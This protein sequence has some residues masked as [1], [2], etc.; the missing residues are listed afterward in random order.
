MAQTEKFS[1][2]RPTVS[3]FDEPKANFFQLF[4]YLHIL[5]S[6]MRRQLLPRFSY[7]G[8]TQPQTKNMQ[9]LRVSG[10]KPDSEGA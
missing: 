3:D 4:M 1:S 2:L 9:Y 6:K 8:H 10:P 7:I 5:R